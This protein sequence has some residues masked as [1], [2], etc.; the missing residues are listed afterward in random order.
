MHIP[1]FLR[2]SGSSLRHLFAIQREERLP[3]LLTLV[4]SVCLNGLFVAQL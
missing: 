4:V 1:S 3:A 2:H